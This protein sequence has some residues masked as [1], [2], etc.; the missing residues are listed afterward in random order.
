MVVHLRQSSN[1]PSVSLA[2]GVA[3][4]SDVRGGGDAGAAGRVPGLHLGAA[5]GASRLRDDAL[6]HHEDTRAGGSSDTER[7]RSC[8]CC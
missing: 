2:A 5:R 3:G 4:V 1:E 8:G 6:L 7:K